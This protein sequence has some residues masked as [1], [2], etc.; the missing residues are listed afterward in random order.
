MRLLAMASVSS[1]QSGEGRKKTKTRKRK[2]GKD[3]KYGTK[4]CEELTENSQRQA[5][6]AGTARRISLGPSR[7]SF[8]IMQRKSWAPMQTS[9]MRSPGAKDCAW[10]RNLCKIEGNELSGYTR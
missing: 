8:R 6:T 7:R 3:S 9:L 2:T 5:T 4:S 10:L 1:G